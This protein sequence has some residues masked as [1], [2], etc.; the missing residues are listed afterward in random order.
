MGASA[1][2]GIVTENRASASFVPIREE[3]ISVAFPICRSD[4]RAGQSRSS[5]QLQK[6]GGRAAAGSRA[7]AA[8]QTT[9]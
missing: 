2:G 7:P 8:T 5:R 4:V 3:I 6:L 9:G 1:F